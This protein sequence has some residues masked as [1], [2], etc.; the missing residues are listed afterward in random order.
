MISFQKTTFL[1]NLGSKVVLIR[2]YGGMKPHVEKTNKSPAMQ[3]FH[4]MMNNL[5]TNGIFL[6]T[7][8]FLFLKEQKKC[9]GLMI[10]F[11]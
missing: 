8:L 5:K 10:I 7:T 2:M 1:R 9:L 11:S 4:R 6:G 3:K